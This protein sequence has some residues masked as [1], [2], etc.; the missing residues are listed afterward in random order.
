MSAVLVSSLPFFS[1]A[2]D[3]LIRR[4]SGSVF[5]VSLDW[6]R[7]QF[8][9]LTCSILASSPSHHILFLA[10]PHYPSPNHFPPPAS[11]ISWYPRIVSCRVVIIATGRAC[12]Y[13]LS[14]NTIV[15][16]FRRILSTFVYAGRAAHSR[17]VSFVSLSLILL[18]SDL[19]RFARSFIILSFRSSSTDFI[20]VY[21]VLHML[22]YRGNTG[23]YNPMQ[24][25]NNVYRR[26]E[27]LMS[28][29]G[30]D[31]SNLESV[32]VVVPSRRRFLPLC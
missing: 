14:L 13:P 28:F 6:S 4:R 24:I 30:R 29:R 3:F 31:R 20:T 8:A 22:M 16:V 19:L 25:E 1:R 32:R 10:Y 11:C 9:I 7:S 21:N 27:L 5:R 17:Y 26:R 2:L 18:L 15:N 23:E 12:P